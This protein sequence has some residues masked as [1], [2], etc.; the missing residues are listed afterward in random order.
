MK[1]SWKG[2]KIQIKRKKKWKR[3]LEHVQNAQILIIL[4]IC[5]V[6]FGPLLSI[7]MFCSIQWFCLGTVK[8]L[9]RLP[10]C[11]GW[12]GFSLS[13]YALRHVFT[14]HGPYVFIEKLKKYLPYAPFYLE[15]WLKS[16]TEICFNVWNNILHTEELRNVWVTQKIWHDIAFESSPKKKQAPFQQ[17]ISIPYMYFNI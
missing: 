2:H 14:L 3:A 16:K 7:H 10:G 12:S 15:P 4:L 11:I 17:K 9:I 6:S 13:A 8:V 1:Y 5:R